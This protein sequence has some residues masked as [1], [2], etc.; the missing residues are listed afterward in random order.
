M[1]IPAFAL[2]DNVL[3]NIET[4]SKGQWNYK[5]N[6]PIGR[7]R[8]TCSAVNNKIYC[9]GGQPVGMPSYMEND[10]SIVEEYNP[11]NNTWDSNKTKMLDN[12]V[13]LTSSIANN[14]IYCFGGTNKTSSPTY[15]FN[16]VL[17]FNPEDNYVLTLDSLNK[18]KT[19]KSL[20]VI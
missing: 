14:K 17:E 7:L 10:Y 19:A 15:V 4:N 20:L 8:L 3:K 11:A 5:A 12:R 16:T 9:F 18:L 2:I 13:F 1:N 6:M